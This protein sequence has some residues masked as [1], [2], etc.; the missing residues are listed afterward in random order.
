MPVARAGP[1]VDHHN[2]ER[3]QRVADAGQLSL[4]IGGGGHVA[5]GQVAKVQLHTRLKAPFQRHFINRDGGAC[6]SIL[7]I[8]R[9]VEVPGGIQVGAVVR[10][11]R[12]PFGCG[13]LAIGVVLG[14]GAGDHGHELGQR[15]GVLLVGDLGRQGRWVGEHIVLQVDGQVHKAALGFGHTRTGLAQCAPAAG[16]HRQDK[17]WSGQ[18]VN[19][20]ATPGRGLAWAGER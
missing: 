11:Q 7:G 2:V 16:A 17:T 9:G 8:L 5:I 18:C 6:S 13:G 12:H 14:S 15:I 19:G 4:H 1:G 10:G 20:Y 3:L